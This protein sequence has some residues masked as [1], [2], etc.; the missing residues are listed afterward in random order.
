MKLFRNMKDS[1]IPWEKS[2][3]R[4]S[5]FWE[6]ERQKVLNGIEIDGFKLSGWL[7]WHINHWKLTTDDDAN[8][9]NI[10]AEI[11]IITPDLRDNEIIINDALLK[12]EKERKGI[13]ILGL[14]QMG[15]TSFMASY[16]G[17]SGIVFKN[18]QNLLMGTNADDL[19]NITQNMDFGLL[20][21]TDYFRI[22]RI[23]RD[24]D[25]ER[26][27][28][29]VKNKKGDNIVHSTYVIRNTGSGKKT[30]K[31]AGVS[32]LKCNLWDE[33]GKDNFL[34]ALTA[35]KPAMLSAN[36]WRT[37]PICSG[38]GGNVEKARDARELFFNCTS[39]NFLEFEQEDGR[40]TGLFMPGWLRQDCKY[41]TTLASYLLSHNI[42]E[43]IPEDSELWIV[44][45]QVSN[46]E[47]AIKKILSELDAFLE[48]GNS[49]EYNRWKAYYPLEIDDIFL[50]ESNN[51]FPI[52]ALKARKK[53]LEA[54]YE[55]E[56]LELYRDDKNNIQ[57]KMSSKR[58]ISK[59]PVKPTDNKDA[60]VL[61]F[62]RPQTDVPH[63]TYCIGIDPV[64]EDSSSDKINSL[65]AIYV[66]KRMYNPMGSFQ[67]SIVCSW[68]GRFQ[69]VKEFHE[70][71]LMIAEWYNA[72]DGVLPENEDKT[73]I[74]YFF[75]KKKG[76]FLADSMDLAKQINPN[77]KSNRVKGLSASTA[78][79]RHY[80]NLMYEEVKEEVELIE[81]DG[82][83][84]GKITT[85][86]GVAKLFDP[87]LIEEMIQYRGKQVATKGVHDGNY[88]SIV[89]F[90]HCLTLARYHD[91]KYPNNWKPK[92]TEPKHH[93]PMIRTP[94]GY[95]TKGLPFI[96][97]KLFHS[98]GIS[99]FP[100]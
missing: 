11:N 5:A 74:Q 47:V 94:W 28:L 26:V 79:Q 55:P 23:S 91:I 34:S 96:K 37:I 45:I 14:R 89:A 69:T 7:Y 98:K 60:P 1:E 63:G 66:Y 83:P 12:A 38:T 36:G 72:I 53:W 16:G 52:D 31:G 85:V 15:K 97:S 59:F 10:N 8:P 30:E 61:C 88:D 46:K 22:P 78:N 13:A 73:L 19:N 4:Y 35:T 92:T 33:I 57:V 9:E 32:N 99:M 50:T 24:W 80:M 54:E 58:P 40:K 76:H 81:D 67:N 6:N 84:E 49:L 27:L 2:D 41:K 51:N 75:Y 100:R 42:L 44:P 77:T 65:A 64:N 87:M 20:N 62:E 39:H 25:S 95:M 82:T 86:T 71:A 56:Y 18:S 43:S 29:G 21:C 17:R 68:R 90:G 93:E 48:S 70:L 3:P